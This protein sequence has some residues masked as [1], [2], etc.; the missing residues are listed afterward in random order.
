MVLGFVGL[1]MLPELTPGPDTF[2]VLRCSLRGPRSGIAAAVG[3]LTCRCKV[4]RP[5]VLYQSHPGGRSVNGTSEVAAGQVKPS[6]RGH[7]FRLIQPRQILGT[8]RLR[9]RAA[10]V[11]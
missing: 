11:S 6:P 5:G 7:C 9:D 4:T 2:L 3:S 1:C 8:G 10:A